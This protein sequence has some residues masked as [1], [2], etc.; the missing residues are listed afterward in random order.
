MMLGT[1]RV[2]CYVQHASVD[3]TGYFLHSCCVPPP[4]GVN[5]TYLQPIAL[6]TSATAFKQALAAIPPTGPN[7]ATLTGRVERA[8]MAILYVV[9]WRWHELRAFASNLQYDWP[10]ASSQQ[11]A[12]D[13]FAR[14]YNATG[15]KMLSSAMKGPSALST[16]HACVFGNNKACPLIGGGGRAGGALYAEVVLDECSASPKSECEAASSWT[17]IAADLEGGTIFKSGLSTAKECY[18]MN[19][20]DVNGE[21][22]PVVA[23]GD[24]TGGCSKAAMQNTFM[25]VGNSS[26]H[27]LLAHPKGFKTSTCTSDVRINCCAYATIR[28]LLNSIFLHTYASQIEP[29]ICLLDRRGAASSKSSQRSRA[30]MVMPLVLQRHQQRLP[31]W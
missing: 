27:G 16:F 3:E 26:L 1:N 13:D 18:A 7:T 9:L 19:V 17:A 30:P 8:S 14:I 6:L 29:N 15:T 11:A 5:K 31:S 22:D 10:L 20:C 24:A 25:S 21:C 4:T 2:L 28:R 12:F 23:Y